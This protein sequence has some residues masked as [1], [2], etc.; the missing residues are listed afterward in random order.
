MIGL[1]LF[2]GTIAY[3]IQIIM[4]ITML[5]DDIKYKKH[6]LISS[7]NMFL[8]LLIP[9]SFYMILIAGCYFAV[10]EHFKKGNKSV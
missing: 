5:C 10:I 9:L 1:L 4:V 2:I 8:V 7:F 3:V 6:T